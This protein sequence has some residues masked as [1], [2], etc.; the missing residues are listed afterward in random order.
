MASE[1]RIG[2]PRTGDGE[3]NEEKLREEEH[4]AE[5]GMQSLRSPVLLQSGAASWPWRGRAGAWLI[6]GLLVC[7]RREDGI[8]GS[9]CGLRAAPL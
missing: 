5:G 6:G 4:E 1:D 7:E 8:I 9:A 2:G 3:A